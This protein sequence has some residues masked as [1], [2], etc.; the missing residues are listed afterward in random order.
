MRCPLG[1][2]R[3]RCYKKA[4]LERKKGC[5][6]RKDK[7]SFLEKQKWPVSEDEGLGVQK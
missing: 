6:N 5:L 1:T 2:A 4:G 7:A 3:S